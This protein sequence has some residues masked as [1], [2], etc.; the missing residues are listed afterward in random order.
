LSVTVK[1]DKDLKIKTE[2]QLKLKLKEII[3]MNFKNENNNNENMNKEVEL[4]N[5]KGDLKM[6]L[7][8]EISTAQS[9]RFYNNKQ[10]LRPIINNGQLKIIKKH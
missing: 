4:N 5:N 6:K 3:K 1:P 2:K 9:K 7:I 10:T 8:S